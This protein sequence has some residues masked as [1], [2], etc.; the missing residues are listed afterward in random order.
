[1]ELAQGGK[2]NREEASGAASP[3]PCYRCGE[4]GHFAR[5]CTSS[6]K[7][8][9]KAGPFVRECTISAKVDKKSLHIGF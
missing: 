7:V 8:D 9:K 5:E 4:E 3:S 2:K 1:M 6:A